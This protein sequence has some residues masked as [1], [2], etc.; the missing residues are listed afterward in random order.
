MPH[1]EE[2]TQTPSNGYPL[3]MNHPTGSYYDSKSEAKQNGQYELCIR[4]GDGTTFELPNER[5]MS[6]LLNIENPSSLTLYKQQ[7]LSTH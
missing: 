6:Y 1:D 2:E 3:G 7:E 4:Y 5:L